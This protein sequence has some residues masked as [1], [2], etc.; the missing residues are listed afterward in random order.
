MADLIRHK[1]S[2]APSAVPAEGD[3]AL[4]EL[5]VNVA[6]GRLF[7][8]KA[9]GDVIDVTSIA[10]IIGLTEALAGKVGSDDPRL[11]DD[12]EWSAE[13][14]AQTEAEDGAATTRRAWTA[15]RVRQAIVAW[16]NSVS[17][18]WGRGF[19]SSTD[20]AAG[21]TALALGTAAT[22][23]I[24]TAANDVTAGRL[25]KVGDLGGPANANYRYL[26]MATGTD[27][28]ADFNNLIVFGWFRTILGGA[29]GSRNPNH[30]DGNT[31]MAANNGVANYYYVFV[32]QHDS[33]HRFQLAV[34]HL[35]G[36]NVSKATIKFRLLAG[37]E[38]DAWDSLMNAASNFQLGPSQ[39]TA[40]A[41]LGLTGLSAR[42]T[43][44]EAGAT[45]TDLGAVATSGAQTVDLNI[46]G[47]Q[48]F[49][50]SMA[51][52]NTTG[53]LTLNFTNVP[54]SGAAV[55]TWHVELVRGGRKTVAFQLDGVSLTPIW[56]GGV[57]PTLSAGPGTR[58]L[59]MFYRMPGRS[60]IYAMLVDSGA[61]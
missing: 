26:P 59:L 61:V 2:S 23:N 27:S 56:A 49:T 41:A 15:Q 18:A 40:L 21:R 48:F 7:L 11:S 12:R 55:T 45:V 38:W 17:S 44:L 10:G 50:A 52:A 46:G 29:P 43:A 4:G 16:W 31:P 6:D 20:A 47:G 25:L 30:P 57:A 1:R 34:P 35:S 60:A 8:K 37:A 42:V 28:T 53:V 51:A 39:A 24:T 54:P 14:V 19:V 36:A 13:T 32:G 33:G 5:A 58:D 22:A 9:S 3:L